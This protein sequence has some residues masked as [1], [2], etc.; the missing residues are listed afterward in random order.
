MIGDSDAEIVEVVVGHGSKAAG[1][2]L[3][4]LN[5][6]KGALV[7]AV[8]RNGRSFIPRGDTVLE[9]GDTVVV[10]ALPSVCGKVEKLFAGRKGVSAAGP[11]RETD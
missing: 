4:E 5:V 9:E 7:G 10:F 2:S 8:F 1:R 3:R 11:G 6:P